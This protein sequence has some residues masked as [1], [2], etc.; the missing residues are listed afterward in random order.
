LEWFKQA[1]GGLFIDPAVVFQ[2]RSR[3]SWV[4]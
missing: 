3:R 4:T 2:H 1:M